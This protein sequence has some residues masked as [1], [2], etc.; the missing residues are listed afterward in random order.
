MGK[1]IQNWATK[2]KS[3]IVRIR[4]IAGIFG[5]FD[6]YTLLTIFPPFNGWDVGCRY[7]CHE[8]PAIKSGMCKRG[9]P[10]SW[11]KCGEIDHG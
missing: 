8:I 1:H 7:C 10:F 9:M 5:W 4:E 2:A 6:Q 3:R 11:H